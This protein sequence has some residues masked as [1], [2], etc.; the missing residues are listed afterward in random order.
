M[1]RL[2]K[3]YVPLPLFLMAV[4]EAV[5]LFASMYIGAVV[6]FSWED[7]SDIE[8]LGPIFPRALIFT[9]V[10]LSIMT[11]FGLHQRDVKQEGEWGHLVRFVASFVAG[12]V[13]MLLV[14][15][16]FPHLHLGRGAFG[17]VFLLAFAG[18]ALTRLVFV[19]LFKLDAMRRR[20]LLLGA[21]SRT[22]KIEGLERDE[23]GER[24]FNLVGCL[25]LNNSDC[26][27][28]RTRI[29]HDKGPILSIARKYKID[30]IVV[31][32]R[33]RRGGGL[34]ADQLLECKLAGIEV[35]DLSSFFERETGQIQVESLNPSWMIFS[36]GFGRS[37][38]KDVSK[39]MFDVAASGALLLLTLPVM[40]ITALLIWLE[41]GGPIF[42]R[43]ERV[44]E[45]GRVFRV[46]KFRSMRQDA[47]RDGVPQ[48]AKKQD[49]RVTR[50]GR[51][52][53]LLR[54]DELPQVFNVFKGDMSFVG[55][56]PERP[57]FV[58]DLT[59]KISYYPSRHTVKPGI[60]GW[61][62]IRYPYGATVED[63]VQKL[64]YDLYYVKNHTLFL[65]LIILFQTAQVI[66]FGKGAR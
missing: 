19:R 32:V 52:I 36:D 40:L 21:G 24:K 34:P 63:A 9:L 35:V 2:F 14:F 66:L 50:V 22:A 3:H 65:D 45:N 10:M 58:E 62:Q 59:K 53:R 27:L 8:S 38:L 28:D 26:C 57:F 17:L 56:R 61:A 7:P 47:E 16:V 60:T 37:P 48:W 42:Y 12:L 1:I 54:I 11:A 43:Q 4:T 25:P 20:V 31:G 44:G 18:T 55:P 13:V 49:S 6:R 33:E 23:Q 30:E 29:L 15:Y 5:V 46:L 64:Q 51:V 39:R 41:S